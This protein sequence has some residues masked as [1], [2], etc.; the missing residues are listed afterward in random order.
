ML[1]LLM[2]YAKG[3][4]LPSVCVKSSLCKYSLCSSSVQGAIFW[5]EDAKITG[6]IYIQCLSEAPSLKVLGA[7]T[8]N[9]Y[10]QIFT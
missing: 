8:S 3:A 10:K 4:V 7:G 1:L 9:P 5:S 6:C 2:Y